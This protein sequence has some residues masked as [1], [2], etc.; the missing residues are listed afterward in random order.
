MVR[1]LTIVVAAVS[2][3]G[4]GL[5]IAPTEASAWCRCGGYAWYPSYRPVYA[6]Y[7]QPV[8][9]RR[10]VVTYAY[11]WTSRP[12]TVASYVPTWRRVA[13]SYSYG[14]Y[15]WGSPPVVAYGR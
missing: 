8:L 6:T 10:P 14:S 2:A 1:K 15:G 11:T 5:T 9:V 12:Y 4:A 3:L 13:Y 7:A